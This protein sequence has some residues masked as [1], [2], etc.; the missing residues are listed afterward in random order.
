VQTHICKLAFSLYKIMSVCWLIQLLN[1]AERFSA[2]II[3][4]ALKQSSEIEL[5]PLYWVRAKLWLWGP[6]SAV[7]SLWAQLPQAFFVPWRGFLSPVPSG[8]SVL[9]A[10]WRAL[11]LWSQTITSEWLCPTRSR[12]AGR[13]DL[14]ELGLSGNS[15]GWLHCYS[16]EWV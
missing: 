9:L 14:G 2:N 5:Q 10:A 4:D 8:A 7:S 12:K 11:P 15:P 16:I 6:A 13:E 1:S 3:R